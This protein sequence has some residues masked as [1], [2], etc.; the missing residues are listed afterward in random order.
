MNPTRAMRTLALLAIASLVLLGSG[1]V[2][3]ATR[4]RRKAR[5]SG[6]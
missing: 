6:A 5:K 2:V 3:L 1:F 4:L